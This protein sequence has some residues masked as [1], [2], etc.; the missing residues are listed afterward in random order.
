MFYSLMNKTKKLSNE[1]FS[2]ML[3]IL[4]K[5]YLFCADPLKL[6]FKHFFKTKVYSRVVRQLYIDSD[7]RP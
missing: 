1:I 7:V 6:P 4:K 5:I 3:I 2:C